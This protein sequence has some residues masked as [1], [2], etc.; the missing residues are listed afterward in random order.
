[1]GSFM[2]SMTTFDLHARRTKI[3]LYLRKNTV[4]KHRNKRTKFYFY[5]K[6]DER[7]TQVYFGKLFN[8]DLFYPLLILRIVMIW[9]F[10]RPDREKNINNRKCDIYILN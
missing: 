5:L 10:M 6:I 8:R 3:Q 2:K 4:P 1:M 7:G 9:I